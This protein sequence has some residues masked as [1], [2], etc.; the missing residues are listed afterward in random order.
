MV[1]T[2]NE[3]RLPNHGICYLGE[4]PLLPWRCLGMILFVS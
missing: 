2:L 3:R 4:L 1:R